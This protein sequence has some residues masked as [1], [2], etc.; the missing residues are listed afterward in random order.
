MTAFTSK[1]LRTPLTLAFGLLLVFC[2][3]C[4]GGDE[5]YQDDNYGTFDTWDADANAE[6]DEN[7]FNTAYYE[8]GYY[9]D[10]DADRSG[11]IEEDEFS[12]MAGGEDFDD[13]DADD[14]GDLDEN[15]AG[16]GLFNMWDDNDD[17]AIDE[18]EYNTYYDSW[19][20]DMGM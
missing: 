13:W 17:E 6:I 5:L 2:T 9:D 1:F 4:A 12:D 15:E 14:S 11:T 19:F 8:S 7:E 3:G 20:G 16:E 18:D 10:W